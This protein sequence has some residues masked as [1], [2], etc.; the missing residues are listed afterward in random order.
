MNKQPVSNFICKSYNNKCSTFGS[1]ISN[2]LIKV[3][4]TKMFADPE[5]SIMELPVNSVDSYNKLNG[6]ESVGKFGMGFFSIIYWL[7]DYPSR[8]LTVESC[9]LKESMKIILRWENN[10][11]TFSKDTK[12]KIHNINNDLIKS[13]LDSSLISNL[14]NEIDNQEESKTGT[15]ITLNCLSNPLTVINVEKIK[16]HLLRLFKIK[17][18][19]LY[20]IFE[21]NVEKINSCKYEKSVIIWLSR[22]E[23]KIMDNAGGITYDVLY[24]S[25]LVPSSSTKGI[26]S[27]RII[28]KVD[29]PEKIKGP[30]SLHIIV[31]G[32]SIVSL[33]K[34]K[35]GFKYIINLP[36]DSHLP[37]SRD[38]IIFSK[39]EASF[40]EDQI[41]YLIDDSN[42]IIELL[43]LLDEYTILNTNLELLNSII[44]IKQRLN[45]RED[46]IFIPDQKIY[47]IIKLHFPH[48]KFIIHP[49]PNI[50]KTE[51][52]LSFLLDPISDSNILLLKSLVLFDF[53]DDIKMFETGGLSK[54]LFINNHYI[55]KN[56][57]WISNII[58][59][60]SDT[61]FFPINT[62]YKM[63]FFTDE[64]LENDEIRELNS[65]TNVMTMANILKM[66]YIGKTLNVE[67]SDELNLPKDLL[68]YF[69]YIEKDENELIKILQTLNSKISQINF[70]FAYGS[71]QK[72]FTNTYNN[73]NNKYNKHDKFIYSFYNYANK[74][75]TIFEELFKDK[76]TDEYKE[77]EKVVFCIADNVAIFDEYND[78]D[79]IDNDIIDSYKYLLLDV[80]EDDKNK[81][82]S[83]E[84]YTIIL[85]V[86]EKI[87]S[88]NN[89]KNVKT[90]LDELLLY[91]SNKLVYFYIE[92]IPDYVMEYNYSFPCLKNFF[93]YYT[94]IKYMDISY[95][96][97][98]YY[99]LLKCITNEEYFIYVNILYE[100]F[101]ILDTYDEYTSILGLHNYLLSEIRRI[102]SNLELNK[103]IKQYVN[104]N[105]SFYDYTLYIKNPLIQSC[106]LY[107]KIKNN[108]KTINKEIYN[109]ETYEF[110][111]STKSLI[112]Y[113]YMHEVEDNFDDLLIKLDKEYKNFRYDR[114]SK[115]QIV[116]IAVNDGT[117]KNFIESVLTET[118]QNS[119][120]AIKSIN[121]KNNE[122]DIMIDDESI[123][124]IDYIGIDNINIFLA[125]LI[126]FYSSKDSSDPNVTG[127]MGTGFFN[128]FRQPWTHKVII[129]TTLNNITTRI[130]ATP[131]VENGLVYDINYSIKRYDSYIN[132]N[133]SITIFLIDDLELRVKTL[134]D[135]NL[136]V[137]NFIG[138]I[139]EI[140]FTLNGEKKTKT[141]E[142]IYETEIGSVI[143]TENLI[144][145]S[146]ILTNGIPFMKFTKFSKEFERLYVDFLA[147]SSNQMIIN[148]NKNI[149]SASQSRTSIYILDEN[150]EKVTVFL[151]NAMYFLGLKKYSCGNLSDIIINNTSSQADPKQ[152]RFSNINY[153]SLPYTTK[154]YANVKNIN[155]FIEYLF[156]NI[157]L[158]FTIMCLIDEIH[159]FEE[160]KN[161]IDNTIPNANIYY[162]VILRWFSNKKKS[163]S[164][165]Q[166]IKEKQ[167]EKNEKYD[168]LSLF[169]NE[170][171]KI[172]NMLV[173]MKQIKIDYNLNTKIPEIYMGSNI[174]DV[175]GYYSP[176]KHII[177][178]S[179]E[180]YN[181]KLIDSKL[182]EFCKLY[183]DDPIDASA[184]MKIDP[185]LKTIFNP[186]KPA[187]T[188][189]HELGHAVQGSDHKGETHGLTT[190]KIGESDEFLMFEDMCVE[191]YKLCVANKLFEIFFEKLSTII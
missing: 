158:K 101:N 32:V 74:I 6:I 56:E 110:N 69:N 139:P 3:A 71:S 189:I 136:F 131:L 58:S 178:L 1:K 83:S 18:V 4:S 148:F 28:N 25:L 149:Y 75:K 133:T 22:E 60:S 108:S 161:M 185:V 93:V 14:K 174:K 36:S 31:N 179:D 80:E 172:V 111:F 159:T 140:K 21:S 64:E 17:N 165:G 183:N 182:I 177:V 53:E 20:L 40:F 48:T 12:N 91:V 146:Y 173:E 112:K 138:L 65:K 175:K 107:I 113:V 143:Y 153:C 16:K 171:W 81:I 132:N 79:I 188:L 23:I 33:I 115:L 121:S 120:D 54:Y 98:L 44:R 166:I 15:I 38:D 151:N 8:Y 168:F 125:L 184:L 11:L 59:Q 62:K 68:L 155:C 13:F 156:N 124:I 135:A 87:N 130:E 45:E 77:L 102:M 100:I 162:N 55:R 37:V 181:Q 51:N 61:L 73:N 30:S 82:E 180:Y 96:D 52:Q 116:E 72:I 167:L 176:L 191:V 106:I 27:K 122:I 147:I 187:T 29:K 76:E 19:N 142:T 128:V 39:Y 67:D 92:C 90:K 35:P 170:Y 66:T 118:I 43:S 46:V 154:E 163:K 119:I 129:S 104:S 152:L 7:V 41:N 164:I 141:F 26:I 117:S 70:N 88:M 190:I 85:K 10:E 127:E 103:L 49:K 126:P 47:K 5:Q 150:K 57:N 109:K 137:E 78:N 157:T 24:K 63:D 2:S 123:T 186:S 86:Q 105:Y 9:T 145:E 134:T 34:D 144:T 95:Q 94:T 169:V 42:D 97:E 114:D 89:I 84:I 50:Y 160:I 99:G